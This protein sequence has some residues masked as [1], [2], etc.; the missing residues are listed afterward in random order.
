LETI[1]S[2]SLPVPE[3]T[4]EKMD[5]F[6]STIQDDL[7]IIQEVIASWSN[8]DVKKEDLNKILLSLRIIGTHHLLKEL[9]NVRQLFTQVIG[10]FEFLKENVRSMEK[11]YVKENA[12]EILK[13]IKK[14]NILSNTILEQINEIGIKNLQIREKTTGVTSPGSPSDL[15]SLRKKIASKNLIKNKIILET[16]SKSDQG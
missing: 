5:I 8:G 15:D 1:V 7:N 13:Y 6:Y 9:T 16:L 3:I 14:E 2:L 10:V 12:K 4:P 11:Q